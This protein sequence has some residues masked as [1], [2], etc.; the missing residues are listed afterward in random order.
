[1]RGAGKVKYTVQFYSKYFLR[2]IFLNTR[3]VRKKKLKID[4]SVNFKYEIGGMQKV[5]VK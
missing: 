1:M 3:T 2:K 5:M 4:K